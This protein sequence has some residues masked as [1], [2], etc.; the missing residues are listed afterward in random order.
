MDD[1]FTQNLVMFARLLRGAGMDV[2]PEQVADLH[3]VL[4]VIGVA[5]REDVYLAAR[6]LFVRRRQ[7]LPVFD[8][9]FELFFRLQDHPNPPV[10]DSTQKPARRV[11]RPKNIQQLFEQGNA[12][13]NQQANPAD[14]ER[15]QDEDRLTYSPFEVL[16]RKDFSRFTADEARQARRLMAQIDWHVGERQ[17]RRRQPARP[18]SELDFARLVRRNLKYGG[19]FFRLP[20]RDRRTK[21]RPVVILADMSGSMEPYTRM[22]LQLLHALHHTGVE[23]QSFVFATRLS[24]ISRDLE[25]RSIDAALKRVTAHVPDWCGGTRIGEAIKTFNFQWARRVLRS[26][27]VVLVLSDGWDQGDLALLGTEMARLQ[28]SC[29]RLIWLSPMPPPAAGTSSDSMALGLRTAL[30]FVDDWLPV[31]NL[32]TLE[33]LAKELASLRA[34]RT[35]RRQRPQPLVSPPKI[36]SAPVNVDL[37][38]M[39][40]SNYVR[41]T[42]VLSARDGNTRLSYGENPDSQEPG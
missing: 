13:K 30:P 38:Q 41:R 1:S 15:E 12:Q 32:V 14:Q 37:P 42:M 35:P 23:V 26:G 3:R 19:E 29:H 21:P 31:Y 6:A 10:V 25:T 40:T 27:A 16:R 5:A 9:A 2:S 8:R 39:G 18:G 22:V 28:R 36:E 34:M 20:K 11:Y 33:I 17:T 4:T 7:D 24:W